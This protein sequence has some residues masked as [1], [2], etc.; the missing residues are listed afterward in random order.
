MDPATE[1][2]LVDAASR[3]PG[4]LVSLTVRDLLRHWGAK[5]RG[6]WIVDTIESDLAKYSLTTMP[7]FTEGWIDNSILLVP[8]TINDVDRASAASTDV[9]GIAV[10]LEERS[11]PEVS[12]Q[13]SSLRSANLG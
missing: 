8:S 3:K 5:R 7:P 9:S 6:Y 10:D 12:L 13:V 11:T 4:D 2:F 1:Q